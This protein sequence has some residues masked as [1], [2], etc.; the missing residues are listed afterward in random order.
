[1]MC[2]GFGCTRAPEPDSQTTAASEGIEI[3]LLQT[4]ALIRDD[5]VYLR[6]DHPL[7]ESPEFPLATL[8]PE[9]RLEP[10]ELELIAQW[11]AQRPDPEYPITAHSDRDIEDAMNR[12][13]FRPAYESRWLAVL[14]RSNVRQPDDRPE[15]LLLVELPKTSP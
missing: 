10:A 1:M 6:F 4:Q 8:G 9:D 15:V 13:E 5:K 14:D 3:P 12:P 11:A 7:I 2:V